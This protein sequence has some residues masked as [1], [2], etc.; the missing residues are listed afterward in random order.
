MSTKRRY[1]S[2]LTDAQWALVEPLLSAVRPGGRPEAH[3]RR[4]VVNAI[5][6]LV[7]TG[8]SWR[9]LP[10]DFPPWETVYW[11]FKRWRDD[12][13]LE[14]MHD[15]LRG[16]VRETEGRDP[17][18]SAAIIDA[19]SVK[20]ADTVGR[21][22]RGYDAGKKTN[23]RKRH[24]VVD[25]IGLMVLVLVTAASVQ[26]RDG[27]RPTLAAVRKRFPTI[28]LIWADGGYAGKL[29]QW[30]KQTARI[31]LEIVRKPEGQRTFEVLP[32]RWVVERTLAWITK[33][34]RLDH[35]YE[36]LP[37]TSVAMV[38]WAMIALM[39]RRL[40][41]TPGRQPWSSP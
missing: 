17:E 37:K 16:A 21:D 11:H 36:R 5:L 35:D 8:C 10:K 32:R 41:P 27:A 38:Q 14:G 12:G 24:I 39:T 28:T 26:D 30:A 6:Y 23:G 3:A 7:R 22:T 9:Q 25:T 40:A 19:Q 18:P 33:C 34:R 2:D 4:E 31:V 15:T 1:P 13:S 29:V 20:G